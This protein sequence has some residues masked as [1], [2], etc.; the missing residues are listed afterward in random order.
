MLGPIEAFVGRER[1]LQALRSAFDAA[2][3]G[4][5]R[6]VTLSG[7][8]GIGKT[9]LALE[10]SETASAR[11]ARIVWSRCDEEAGAPPYWPWVRILRVLADEVEPAVLQATLD[12]GAPD[13]AELVPEFR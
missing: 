10:L 1:E 13:L 7:E 2:S 6:I 11:S 3:T 4:A 12:T 5:G 9:R 8:P